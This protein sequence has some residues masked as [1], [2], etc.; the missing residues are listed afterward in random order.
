M[1]WI[2]TQ[3]IYDSIRLKNRIYAGDGTGTL[4]ITAGDLTMYNAVNDGNPTISLG[5]SATERLEIKAQYES[6][7][8]GLDVVKFTTYTAGSSDND[9]RYSFFVD[10]VSILQIKDSALNLSQSMNLSIGG[11]DIL[12]DSSGTT[13][14]S[15]IDDLDA[16]TIAT[17]NSHLT[18]GDI[19]G[20]TAGTGLSGGGTSGAVTLN[21]DAEQTQIIS[22]GTIETGVWQGTAIAT[23]HIDPE[24]T[25]ITALGTIVTGTWKGTAIATA[26]IADD[27]I[28]E[29]KLDNTLLAEIDANTA[30]AA[31]VTT[32]L[33]A[34][35]HASQI[36]INSSDG[37]NVVVAEASGS[38]AGVMTVA[39]H[40]KLDGIETSATADQTKSDIDGLAITT[41]GTVDTG[42]WQGTKIT[43]IYTNSSGKRFGN[44]IKLIPS[45]FGTNADGGNTRLGI[46][47]VDTAGDDYGMSTSHND[48]ELFAFVSIPEGMKATHVE[49]FGRRAKAVEVFEVQI[50]ATTMTSK[51]TGTCG[52]GTDSIGDEEFAITNV[53]STATNL[54][55]IEV[56]VTS[57]SA[58][59][60]YGG[61]VKIAAV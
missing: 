39:H 6:G 32:N 52:I 23:A 13:T 18:A 26:Y 56:T 53:T 14:L 19:T 12:T 60:V 50:N 36:T 25:N 51:G 20:V 30:K 40:D 11:V 49:V 8:Q 15:N 4:S 37:T 9:S 35:T 58:D 5:S 10:E 3:T 55:A 21:V 45:D 22:V 7:A 42:V 31:N 54:L 2:G 34:T 28:T 27:A 38:I 61:R 44:Y 59:K 29:N 41:V 24:Q 16:T 43:D 57:N 47:Y 33:T 46:G 48:T 1:K 17:F